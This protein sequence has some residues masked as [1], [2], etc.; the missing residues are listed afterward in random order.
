MEEC[1]YRHDSLSYIQI[2]ILNTMDRSTSTK[3]VSYLEFLHQLIDVSSI[4]FMNDEINSHA[5]TN[6]LE[7]E[8]K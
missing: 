6:N 1:P 4:S 3:L 7:Y 5:K 2:E 8:D